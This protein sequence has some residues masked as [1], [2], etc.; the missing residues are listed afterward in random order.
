MP[1]IPDE[2]RKQLNHSIDY[3]INS[4]RTGKDDETFSDLLGRINY[5][6]TRVLLQLLGDIRYSKVAMA[7]GVLV[8]IKDEL[9]RRLVSAYEDQKIISEGDIPEYKKWR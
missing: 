4:I 8:N 1:Y 3:M 6:F 9:Y 7:T 5:C 2:E